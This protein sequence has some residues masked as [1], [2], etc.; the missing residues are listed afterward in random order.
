MSKPESLFFCYI[1]F[2]DCTVICIFTYFYNFLFVKTTLLKYRF[3][4]GHICLD[5]TWTHHRDIRNRNVYVFVIFVPHFTFPIAM[6][7]YCHQIN[8]H[9]QFFTQFANLLLYIW[10]IFNFVWVVKNKCIIL[11]PPLVL[12]QNH[13][14]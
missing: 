6:A 13:W 14:T 8:S 1:A 9:N 4:T 10:K 5:V 7:H 3:C 12:D 2:R 11:L